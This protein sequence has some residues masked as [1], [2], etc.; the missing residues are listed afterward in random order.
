MMKVNNSR[1]R[2][3]HKILFTQFGQIKTY[4]W[5]REQLSVPLDQRSHFTRVPNW[6]TRI[7]PNSTQNPESLPVAK[8]LNFT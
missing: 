8:R 3:E 5:G 1:E 4:V 7:N 2:E 6:V